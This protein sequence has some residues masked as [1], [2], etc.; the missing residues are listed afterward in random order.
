MGMNKENMALPA[1]VE[2]PASAMRRARRASASARE[3]GAGGGGGGPA[4]LV[5]SVAVRQRRIRRG[6]GRAQTEAGEAAGAPRCAVRGHD[7]PRALKSRLREQCLARLRQSRRFLVH[8]MR[9]GRGAGDD[10]EEMDADDM[11]EVRRFALAHFWR[12][13]RKRIDAIAP[14]LT[15]AAVLCPQN[16]EMILDDIIQSQLEDLR[17]MEDLRAELAA[18]DHEEM[19]D[20]LK[21]YVASMEHLEDEAEMDTIDWRG[22]DG[23]ETL[24]REA[25]AFDEA[26]MDAL[27]YLASDMHVADADAAA[28]A[29]AQADCVPCPICS[30]GVL[31]GSNDAMHVR[32]TA[33]PLLVRIDRRATE[34]DGGALGLVRASLASLCLE[35]SS[36]GGRTCPRAPAFFIDDMTG[37]LTLACSL[38]AMHITSRLAATLA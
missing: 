12:Q 34:A 27:V 3:R 20:F 7:A 29:A 6:S 30:H 24:L 22:D 13:N 19:M 37:M 4:P 8:S 16:V 1:A 32:C 35:H 23:G 26:E 10:A 28:A 9:V 33:C 2:T 36:S 21:A 38:C 31:T 17:D 11:G 5:P 25:E 15:R 18:E 14:V